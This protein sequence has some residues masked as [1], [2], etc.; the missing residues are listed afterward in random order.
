[1]SQLRSPA[2]HDPASASSWVNPPQYAEYEA[3]LVDIE[4]DEPDGMCSRGGQPLQAA[5][6][7]LLRASLSLHI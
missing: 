5:R 6:H 1:M 2:G 7:L 3:G 4:F